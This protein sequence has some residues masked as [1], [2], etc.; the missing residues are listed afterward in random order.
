MFTT[1]FRSWLAKMLRRLRTRFGVSSPRLAVRAILP[2]HIKLLWGG[3]F[4]VLFVVSLYLAFDSGKRSLGRLPESESGLSQMQAVRIAQ[5]EELSRL[6]SLISSNES[7]QAIERAA[8]K[9]LAEENAGLIADNA[10]MR[11][12]L[13]VYERLVKVD[14]AKDAAVSLD[15]LSLLRVSPGQYQ[16]GFYLTPQGARRGRELK[17]DLQIVLTSRSGSGA[18]MTLPRTNETGRDQYRISLR[19][20][21]HIEGRFKLAEDFKPG[22]AEFRILENGLLLTSKSFVIEER[23]VQ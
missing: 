5:E 11:E 22:R 20:I 6:R 13:A 10:R 1:A 21:R 14:V 9:K 16:Y 17:L 18:N 23:H 15:R 7:A 3:G 8:Q 12:E 19:N 2:W 4:L